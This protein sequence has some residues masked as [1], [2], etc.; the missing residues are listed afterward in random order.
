MSVLA[1]L[2][3][4]I[5]AG[6]FLGLWVKALLDLSRSGLPQTERLV[7]LIVLIAV[8]GLGL[9]AWLVMQPARRH[10]AAR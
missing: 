10:M 7:W 3:V 2:L 5:V 9:V 1:A 6:A 4:L 8:P